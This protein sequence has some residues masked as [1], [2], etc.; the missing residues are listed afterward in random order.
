MGRREE[1]A[2][3]AWAATRRGG[4][5][6]LWDD[7]TWLLSEIAVLETQLE[8]MLKATTVRSSATSGDI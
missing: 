6:Q 7:V 5:R 1:I 4:D 3:R 2:Q 8:S